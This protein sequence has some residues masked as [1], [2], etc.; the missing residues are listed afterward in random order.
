MTKTYKFQVK[1][2]NGI[3]YVL[4]Q[5]AAKTEMGICRAM[6]KAVAQTL[7]TDVFECLP[8]VI[9]REGVARDYPL[10]SWR[11]MTL[12]KSA[13]HYVWKAAHDEIM[14]GMLV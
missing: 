7:G 6:G 2:D 1:T 3:K 5:T 14:D 12:S 13:D 8:K 9:W 11:K 4:C 10:N